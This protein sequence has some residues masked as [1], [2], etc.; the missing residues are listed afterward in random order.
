MYRPDI[1]LLLTRSS[2]EIAVTVLK[3]QFLVSVSTVMPFSTRKRET[4]VL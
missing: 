4:D 1:D 3:Y 2:A